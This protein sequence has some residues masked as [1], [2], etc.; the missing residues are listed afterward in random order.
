MLQQGGRYASARA[1][2][3]AAGWRLERLTPPSRLFTANGLRTGPDGRIYIAQVSGSQISALDLQ[4]G[5]IEVVSATGGQIVGPDDLA[6]DSRGD[7]Y[8]T[9]YMDGRVSVLEASGRTRVLRDDVPAAN[10]V[11]FHQD[12]LYIDECRMGGRVLELDRAGGPPRVLLDDVPL[13]NALAPGPDGQLYF[14]V[15]G[16][17]EIWRISPEGGA[18]ERVTGGLA[19][20]VAV[21]FDPQGHIVAPQSRTGE[22][23][24]IDPRT[25]A[26]MVLATLDPG[27]DNLTFVGER[28]FVSHMTDGRITEIL[29]DGASR[30]LLAG[31]LQRPMDLA[32]GEDGQLYVADN[33]SFYVLPRGGPLQC[34]GRIF[35]AGYPG[36]VRGVAPAG[37]GRFAVTTASGRVALYRPWAQESE[38]LAQGL[39]QLY[40]V[41]VAA[42]GAIL[43]AELGTGRLLSITAGGIEVVASGLSDPI[44]VALA[45]DGGCLV[46]EAGAGRVARVTGSGVEAVLDGLAHP[47]GIAVAGERLYVVEAGA[48]QVIAYD[49]ESGARS[50]VATD[51]PVGA[52]PGV[53][54]KPLRGA[55]PFVGPMGPFAGIAVDAAGDL[56]VSADGE[57]SVMALR[58]DAAAAS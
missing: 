8:V 54:P 49:L 39:D 40:G 19:H 34:L 14:P 56:Y 17:D 9:E 28:L 4:S 57:G 53:T 51:L 18:A 11:T 33:V 10:G 46:A 50:M 26:R 35:G 32:I 3:A 5:E 30:E 48:K 45:P 7:L 36:A 16:A 6:F 13:P 38:E 43:A 15:I 47:Q 31:G 42:G 58:R 12:R 2:R 27:L 44:G 21:K 25:G 22:V 23:L 41:A 1:P 20:P 24:R 55:P 29:G 52:P 37:A